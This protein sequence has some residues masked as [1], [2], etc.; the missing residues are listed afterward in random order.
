LFGCVLSPSIWISEF[1]K[2]FFPSWLF[3][4]MF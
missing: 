3:V 1:P 4:F 2:N